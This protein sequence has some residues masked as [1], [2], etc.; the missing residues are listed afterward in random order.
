MV[1]GT[2]ITRRPCWCRWLPIRSE[3]SPPTVISASMPC[4]TEPLHELV[5]EIDLLPA[6]VGLLDR[7]ARRVA[8]VGRAEDRATEM[9]DPAHGLTVELDQTTV[10]I[11]LRVHDPVEAVADAHDLPSAVACRDGGGPDDGVETRRVA[12]AGADCDLRHSG[13]ERQGTRG[14]P[15]LRPTRLNVIDRSPGDDRSHLETTVHLQIRRAGVLACPHGR[16]HCPTHHRPRGPGGPRHRR[17]V[18]ARAALRR[19]ARRERRSGGGHRTSCRPTRRR[20]RRDRG[21]GRHLS[22]AG[23]RRHRCRAAHRGGRIGR[24]RAG[25]GPDPGQQR[26]DPRCAVRHQ[27]AAGADRSGPRHEP[28]GAVR[29]VVRGGAPSDRPAVARP[30]RQ[31][32]LGRR[33]PLLGRR[34]RARTRSPRPA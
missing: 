34:R 15:P 11:L 10:G 32:L 16:H 21:G 13:H 4:V 23:P 25:S 17:V 19:P 27:D 22:A 14:T 8:P 18:R 2:P 7:V 5:G 31:H 12:A 6:P 26:R 28:A 20:C 1:L 24:G 9:G 29:A 30:D 33:V 3:P